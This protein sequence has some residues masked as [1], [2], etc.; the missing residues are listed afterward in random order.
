MFDIM[1]R[2]IRFASGLVIP[3]GVSPI[4][5]VALG[6]LVSAGVAQDVLVEHL[7]H[8]LQEK[9]GLTDEDIERTV[10]YAREKY[11]IDYETLVVA[12]AD[13]TLAATLA[14]KRRNAVGEMVRLGPTLFTGVLDAVTPGPDDDLLGAH[15]DT[16]EQ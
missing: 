5:P 6:R 13:E 9:T 14:S 15:I 2:F 3:P 7:I 1:E 16:P 10:E 4:N 8:K 12:P 11:L